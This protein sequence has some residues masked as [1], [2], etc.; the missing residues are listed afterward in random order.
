MVCLQKG[1]QLDYKKTKLG[2][3]YIHERCPC[4][5]NHNAMSAYLYSCPFNSMA[6]WPKCNYSNLDTNYSQVWSSPIH[7]TIKIWSTKIHLNTTC[8]LVFVQ[9]TWHVVLGFG[10]HSPRCFHEDWKGWQFTSWNLEHQI[11]I[12]QANETFMGWDILGAKIEQNNLNI[13]DASNCGLPWFWDC[14][15][16]ICVHN[17][18]FFKP[19]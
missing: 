5:Q 4:Q 6:K 19:M 2:R 18:V 10:K 14:T 12:C 13:G 15:W 3:P 9:D 17:H 16:T 1:T 8:L 7:Y 11:C